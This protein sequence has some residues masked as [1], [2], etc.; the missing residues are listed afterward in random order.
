M[1]SFSTTAFDTGAFDTDAFFLL[2]AGYFPGIVASDGGKMWPPRE[3]DARWYQV[4]TDSG[5]TQTENFQ[6]DVRTAL[7]AIVGS[8]GSLDDLWKKFKVSNGI[9]DI[10]EPFTY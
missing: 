5:I 2:S 4:F 1:S 10:S 3:E 8:R 6:D 7:I 9:T